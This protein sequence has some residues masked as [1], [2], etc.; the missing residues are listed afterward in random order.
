MHYIDIEI[1]KKQIYHKGWII[2]YIAWYSLDEEY[3]YDII[4]DNKHK[5]IYTNNK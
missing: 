5:T 2:M 3:I 4:E 1:Q